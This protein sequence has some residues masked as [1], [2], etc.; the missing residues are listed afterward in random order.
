MPT[1]NIGGQKVKV[2]DEFLSLAPD[3]Q[4]AAVDEI[5]KSLSAS[6]QGIGSTELVGTKPAQGDQPARVV[7]GT[8]PKSDDRDS[9]LGKIDS[10]VRG[11]ADTMTFGLADELAAGLGGLTGI[12]G[13]RGDFA[14]N[15]A[16]E[17]ATDAADAENRAPLRIFGQLGG[18]LAQAGGLAKAG[19]SFGANALKR[20]AGM[21]E[22]AFGSLVDGGILGGLHGAGSGE[23]V[24]GRALSAAT[25]AT[26][27]GLIGGA[28][29]FA[30]SGV[31]LA[32]KPV[33]APIL[34]RLRPDAYAEDALGEGLKRTGMTPQDIVA[35]LRSAAADQQPMFNVAD[36]MGNSGQRL[37]STVARN[38]NGARQQVVDT[39]LDRQMDQGRRV[40]SALQE[41]SGTPLT[42]AQYKELLEAR[43][44]TDAARNYAPVHSEMTPINVTGPVSEAN[45]AISPIAN[46]IA[47][48]QN[49]VPTD[50]AGRAAIEGQEASIRDP[51]REALKEARS[52][53]ASPQLTIVGVEKAF[54][55]K[56][57]IDQMI[58]KAT[59]KGQGAL[60]NQLMPIRDALDNQLAATSKQYAAARNAYRNAS[61]NIEA[62]GTGRDMARPR[63]RAQ[64]NLSTFGALPGDEARRAA[65]IGY[66]D[67]LIAR[68]E[69]QA[70]TMSNSARPLISESYRQELP[71]FAAPGKA[72]QLGR[73][74]AREQR[75]F[76]TANAALG[77]SKTAD[78]LAD[79]ADMAR[80]DPSIMSKLLRGK[81]V[82]AAISA[83][84]KGM[85][86]ARGQSTPVVERIARAMMET[87]PEIAERLLTRGMTAK[88]VSDA[89]RAI[90]QMIVTNMGASASGRAAAHP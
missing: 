87:N 19:L 42:A 53:M 60:V 61:E 58:A 30:L 37:L 5:A 86:E 81:V 54:R 31:S 10:I 74:I 52:Y 43:R 40:A 44:A 29:P 75:M 73:R 80:F 83:I 65:R 71:A 12:G 77:G 63:T 18:G 27:G 3:Q 88:N 79:A 33:L 23:G 2:G 8:N 50:L 55:A 67:P 35:S 20:G 25:G 9:L 6:T 64:D 84:A 76:E 45:A 14:G 28:A 46:R 17:R 66:F 69:N 72:D 36:A 4:N 47:M 38:P 62:I 48:F 15:L 70:G 90:I 11:A 7:I 32:A 24:E 57:N 39:I 59:E 1:L 41:A 26:G 68:A 13:R 22:K 89:R 56:V 78:N 16:K 34:S 49:R 82:D 21:A 51:I 85:D